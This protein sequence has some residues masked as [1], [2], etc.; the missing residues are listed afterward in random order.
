MEFWGL[1]LNH[2]GTSEDDLVK[3]NEY[4]EKINKLI[5]EIKRN[6][7]EMEKLKYNDEEVL[8][9]YSDFFQDILN[10]KSQAEVYRK[11]LSDIQGTN[12]MLREGGGDKREMGEMP[13]LPSLDE[14]EYIFL[15]AEGSNIGTI[16]KASLGVCVMFGYSQNDLVGKHVDFIMPEM[17]QELHKQLLLM[18]LNK[19]KTVMNSNTASNTRTALRSSYKEVF[20]FG[21]N[22]LKHAVPFAMKTTLMCTQDQSELFFASKITNDELYNE[23]HMKLPS[24][25]VPPVINFN[26]KVC[27]VLTDLD[28]IIQFYTPN[29]IKFLGFKSNSSGN[30]DITKS[31][32]DFNNNEERYDLA[33]TSKNEIYKEKY[34]E[35]KLII[36]KT[37]LSEE[38]GSHL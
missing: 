24:P 1:L 32:S 10:D 11:R 21:K 27:Y 18:K 30:M 2:S 37:A 36:W 7:V 8:V 15:S 23:I 33:K 38:E 16:I 22:K 3:M 26:M 4:G 6:Y 9:L 25:G 31:I 17:Y 35:P 34:F 20:A 14:F 5:A 12:A 29:A 28:F 19:Y 13:A